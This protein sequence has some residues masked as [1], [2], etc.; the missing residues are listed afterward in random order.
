MSNEPIVSQFRGFGDETFRFLA[1]LTEHNEKAWFDANRS[2]YEAH[3]LQPALAFI[4]T[5]GPRLAAELPDDVR[6]EARINGSLFR[7]NRDIRF[8]KDKTPYKN[9]LDLWF[10]QGERHGWESPGYFMHLLPDHLSIGAGMHGF[11]KQTLDA[12]R[13]AVVDDAAG[14]RLEAAV[15][16]VK[17]AG[18]QVHG[19]ARK[20]V[21]RGF[22]AGHPRAAYLLYESLYA[23]LD[24]PIPPNAAGPAFVGYCFEHFR[25]MSPLNR[26][27][28]S[29]LSG[30]AAYPAT[31]AG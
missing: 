19:A 1:E 22:D 8:S 21:P 23:S 11:G 18:Y 7:I 9:H 17:G 12:F 4:E 30:L 6:F 2:R 13:R 16:A 31:G 14:E 26:Y 29:I 20:S 24:T 28:T 27:L 3:Y 10:W 15:G 25:G 5:L